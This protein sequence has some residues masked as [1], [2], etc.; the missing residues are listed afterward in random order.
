MAERAVFI[1]YLKEYLFRVE[2]TEDICSGKPNPRA[3]VTKK[4]EKVTD[5]APKGP[6]SVKTR[7]VSQVFAGFYD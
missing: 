4:A 3:S 5:G 2:D 7:T 1:I 6:K